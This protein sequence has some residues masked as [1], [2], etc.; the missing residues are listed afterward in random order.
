MPSS[1]SSPEAD[2]AQPGGR[3]VV[4]GGSGF[5]GRA[6]VRAFVE[7]GTPVTVIDQQPLPEDLRGDLVT[8]VAGDL[9]D[10]AAREAAVTEGAAGIVHLA[11]I[12]SVLRSVDRP[13]ETYAANVAVTQEL[14]ELA[15]LRGLGQF[16]LASTNAVVGDIGR[17]TISES[18]PL[19][20]LTP[21]GATKAACEMLLSG[22]AG[23][24][25]LATCALRFTNI[26]GPGMGH[27]DSFIPRLMR[28]ALAGAGVEV[29]GDGSQSRDFVHVDDVV[30]GVLA[31]WDK[32]Y[33]GT[34]IIGAGRSISVTELIEAVRTATGRPLPVT[35][36]PAK[37]GEMPAV[38]VDVAKAG[39]ELGYTPSVELTDGLRTVW[40]DFQAAAGA[41]GTA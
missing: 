25:G 19:R 4:T 14:L 16:V 41:S 39:R 5:V 21:Y 40:E 30:R 11:A 32:Q 8:H 33:S 18:L 36:V 20:P 28:A 9:G 2:A 24:Y 38:I 3:V 35:H 1:V 26:Y 29:Y 12:T 31:A 6:V 10:P 17:G 37:N 22:Y 7:R 15:R 27:K 34:A 23:A 13:A